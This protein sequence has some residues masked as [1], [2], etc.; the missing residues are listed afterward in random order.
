MSKK[1]V[2]RGEESRVR[3][4]RKEGEGGGKGNKQGRKVIQNGQHKNL[5]L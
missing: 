4:G 2:E 3:K 5:E 1:E